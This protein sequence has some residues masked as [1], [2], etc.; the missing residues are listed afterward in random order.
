[1]AGRGY[2]RAIDYQT[3]QVRWNHEISGG[4]GAGVLTTETGVTF[5][6]DGSG[7]VLALKTSDGSTLWHASI[8]GVGNS[9]VTIE[10]DGKQHLLVGGSSTLY[11]WRLPSN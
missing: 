8:G 2:V 11:A 5:T 1:V 10:I 9:P 6:G 3:G 4:S 7:N